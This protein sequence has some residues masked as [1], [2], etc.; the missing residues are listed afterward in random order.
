MSDIVL[1]FVAVL[2][3]SMEEDG[4]HGFFQESALSMKQAVMRDG[5]ARAREKI[6]QEEPE[7]RQHLLE[8]A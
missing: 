7:S 1:S 2:L 8:Q 3:T 6:A 4:V 5:G